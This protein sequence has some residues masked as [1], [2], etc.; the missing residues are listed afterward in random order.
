MKKKKEIV[1][2][3]K[4]FGPIDKKKIAIIMEQ[5]LSGQLKVKEK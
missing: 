1:N 3:E 2:L 5:L 4:H